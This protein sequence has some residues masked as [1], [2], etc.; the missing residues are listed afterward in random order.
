MALSERKGSFTREEDERLTV[1]V[2]LFGR[3]WIQVAKFVPGRTQSQCRDRYLNS[4][5][6]SLKWGGWTKE[7]DLRLEAAIV[8]HRFCWSKVAEDV[9]PRTDSQCRKRWK[10]LFPDQV[11]LLQEARKTLKSYLAS[12]F[13]AMSFLFL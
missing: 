7:E 13:A 3:K 4:L 9:P 2:M 5:D 1:A 10:V 8:K 12:K 11:P 6:P